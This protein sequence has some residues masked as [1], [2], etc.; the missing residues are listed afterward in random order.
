MAESTP[1]GCC[2]LVHRRFQNSDG[3]GLEI[4]LTEI[5]AG[6][7]SEEHL[8]IRRGGDT[9]RAGAPRGVEHRHRARF[10]IEAAVDAVLSREPE[11]A[12][13]IKSGRVEVGVAPLLG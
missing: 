4:D 6:E 9:V 8:A 3:P 12:L 7:R 10:G 13:A 5:A 11:H 2:R 1:L